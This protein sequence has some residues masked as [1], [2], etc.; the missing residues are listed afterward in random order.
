MNGIKRNKNPN[1]PHLFT[2]KNSPFPL[3]LFFVFLFFFLG[4]DRVYAQDNK[5][6][7]TPHWI[8]QAQ[9]AGYYVALDQGFYEEAGL[10]VDIKHIP[11]D[12]SSFDVLKDGRA[13]IVSSF[14][15]D[16]LKQRAQGT[17]LV[18]FAQLSQHSA[19]MMVTKKES[20]IDQISDLHNKKLAIWSSGFDDIPVAFMR[21]NNYIIKLVRILSTINLFLMDGVDALTVMYY[22][23]YDQI[24]NSGID[25]D[26]LNKFFFSDYGFDIP[27][28]GLYCLENTLTK[29]KEA[30]K[31][32]V[33]ATLR[34]WEYAEQN[35]EV[36]LDLVVKEMDKAH[37]PNNRAHQQWMLD[38]ILELMSPGDKNV[39]KGHLLEQD[40]HRA[41]SVIQANLSSTRK[42]EKVNRQ[43]FYKPLVDE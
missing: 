30:L 14:L 3:F 18:N 29:R 24:I 22:N 10:D 11:A 39:K 26:E 36:A 41:W 21:E 13:D 9:F 23:E 32:F 37:L 25:E 17:P 33:Q 12:V 8:P 31:K 20:G 42:I 16:G 40:F 4:S 27:E 43:D 6:T 28:D 19:L 7:F 34:G 2:M 35:K 15:L 38:K 5:L 1:N